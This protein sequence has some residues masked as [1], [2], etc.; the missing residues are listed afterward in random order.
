MYKILLYRLNKMNFLLALCL[1]Y[2]LMD[3]ST[4]MKMNS[5]HIYIFSFMIQMQ[6]T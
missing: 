4:L 3:Q 6:K 5:L 2:V 1:C